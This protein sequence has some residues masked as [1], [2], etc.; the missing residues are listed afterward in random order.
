MTIP[1]PPW[2]LFG[3]AHLIITLNRTGRIAPVI[4]DPLQLRSFQGWTPG[5]MGIVSY[6]ES[7]VGAYDE[8]FLAPARV[9]YAGRSGL[10]VSHIWVDSEPS[11]AGGRRIWGLAKERARFDRHAHGI[12]VRR[13]NLEVMTLGFPEFGPTIPI[14]GSVRFLSLQ[15]EDVLSWR[16]TVR[17]RLRIGRCRWRIPGDSPIAGLRLGPKPMTI[18][19][20]RFESTVASPTRIRMDR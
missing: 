5:V 8:F 4:P 9:R 3:R 7:P 12:T 14:R 17:G 15:G 20:N 19:L 1:S 13:G 2:R 11:Q 10:F 18:E 16:V 6:E